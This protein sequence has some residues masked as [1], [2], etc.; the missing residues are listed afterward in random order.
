MRPASSRM[1]RLTCSSL[2]CLNITI[3]PGRTRRNQRQPIMTVFGGSAGSML[4]PRMRLIINGVMILWLFGGPED[5]CD[6]IDY[7]QQL[8]VFSR[9]NRFFAIIGLFGGFLEEIVEIGMFL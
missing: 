8:L 2:F 3:S 5:F 4:P 1:T 9:V 7:I 6:F